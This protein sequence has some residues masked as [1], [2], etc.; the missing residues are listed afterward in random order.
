MGAKTHRRA[1][2]SRDAAWRSG[3]GPTGRAMDQCGLT[4]NWGISVMTK[5]T[6]NRRSTVLAAVIGTVLAS[7]AGSA[8]AI[9]FE[10]ENGGRLNWNTTLSVG[11]SWRAEDPSRWLYTRADGSL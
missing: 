10:F 3:A 7:Y 6:L 8:A 9:D 1:E 2:G 4:G 5:E 11:S